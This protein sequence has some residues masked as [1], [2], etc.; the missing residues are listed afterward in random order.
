LKD[1]SEIDQK[2]FNFM[3]A[4]V[5]RIQDLLT[6][7]ISREASN[8]LDLVAP[9]N[10]TSI[11]MPSADTLNIIIREQDQLV[12]FSEAKE[13]IFDEVQA[14]QE[15][16]VMDDS[17]SDVSDGTGTQMIGPNGA[18]EN[19]PN[20][21]TET[22]DTSATIVVPM[23][24]HRHDSDLTLV[25]EEPEASIQSNEQSNTEFNPS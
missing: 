18:P 24:H 11:S 13:R 9:S 14:M 25:P 3:E 8:Q 15:N 20:E 10:Q 6:R 1:Q 5:P 7:F 16:E 22:D 4:Q 17:D 12:D 19:L 2:L 23:E 21:Q